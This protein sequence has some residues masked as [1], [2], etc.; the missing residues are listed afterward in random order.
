MKRP[1]TI[2]DCDDVLFSTN[3]AAIIEQNKKF[4]TSYTL[5]DVSCW[6]ISGNEVIDGRL[7]MFNDPEFVKNQ[8]LLP[9][10][11]KFVEELYKI[12]DIRFC[13]AVPPAC[14]SVRAQRIIDDFDA[15]PKEIIIASDK[16]AINADYHLDDSA[17]NILNS[18]A[19]HPVLF[20]RPW[21]YSVSGVTSVARYDDFLCFVKYL[22]GRV[23]F[24]GIPE[25]GSFICLVGPSG[26]GKTEISVD[27]YK[28]FGFRR[29]K[30]VTTRR[31]PESDKNFFYKPVS[32]NE[33]IKMRNND[34]FVE[35]T[36]YG[37]EHYGITKDALMDFLE[38]GYTSI[39]PLDMC[40]AMAIKNL[41]PERTAIVFVEKEKSELVSCILR[42]EMPHEEKVLRLL[43]LDSE[44]ANKH[45][46][47]ISI[48]S[49]DELKKIML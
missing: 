20:R 7:N 21:N 44:L 6:G 15:N 16:S 9:G 24:E 13:T 1:I 11:K 19:K 27:A 45:L 17:D 4:G 5:E 2:L 34:E 23:P 18:S 30:T 33:F 49:T 38:K 31:R 46:C 25:K 43:N 28:Q 36:V 26:S 48:R 22:E 37:G 32:K 8:P 47:D 3:E 10:A 14:M 39:I 35:T 42:K 12:S 41:F 40:G 29:L